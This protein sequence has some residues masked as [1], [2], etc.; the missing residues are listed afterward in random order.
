MSD[1]VS[2]SPAVSPGV[3]AFTD[4]AS[5]ATA[6]HKRPSRLGKEGGPNSLAGDAWRGASSLRRKF[7]AFPPFGADG[8]S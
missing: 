5:A 2:P 3:A 4:A 8:R 6:V 1:S 7:R